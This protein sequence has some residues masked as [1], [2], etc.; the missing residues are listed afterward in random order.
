M[1]LEKEIAEHFPGA[2]T[3]MDLDNDT[4]YRKFCFDGC[5]F[6]SPDILVAKKI[7]SDRLKFIGSCKNIMHENSILFIQ[8]IQSDLDFVVKD[9]EMKLIRVFK[10][11]LIFTFVIK[12]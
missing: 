7:P 1:N 4:D 2:K 12:K 10:E 11:G 3:I 9:A 6:I 8:T 5:G